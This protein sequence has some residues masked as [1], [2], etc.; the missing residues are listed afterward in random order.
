MYISK[1]FHFIWH[2][3][4]RYTIIFIIFPWI[5]RKVATF[6]CIIL[7]LSY[8]TYLDIA[9]F[10]LRCVLEVKSTF[11]ISRKNC[12]PICLFWSFISTWYIRNERTI[13]NIRSAIG[14]FYWLW[15]ANCITVVKTCLYIPCLLTVS[16]IRARS[17]SLTK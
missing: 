7:S 16:F 12:D 15:L 17:L 4:C 1:R 9:K 3:F 14:W 6:W 10:N 5:T 8:L 11:W 2:L 13:V